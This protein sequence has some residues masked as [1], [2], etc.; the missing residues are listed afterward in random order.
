[1][2]TSASTLAT[3]V[4]RQSSPP[5]DDSSRLLDWMPCTGAEEIVLVFGQASQIALAVCQQ[6]RV[7]IPFVAAFHRRYL[8]N[9]HIIYRDLKPERFGS[10]LRGCN[11]K[12]LSQ[13]L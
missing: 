9:L 10:I 7:G 6:P 5:V 12:Q 3:L 13:P 11:S 1:M 2:I 4:S 8:H